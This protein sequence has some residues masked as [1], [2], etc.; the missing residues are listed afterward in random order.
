MRLHAFFG[1]DDRR[2]VGNRVVERRQEQGIQR[3]L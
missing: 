2:S 1:P 3:H